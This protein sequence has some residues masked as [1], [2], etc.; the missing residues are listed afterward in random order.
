[1]GFSQ[2]CRE[3]ENSKFYNSTSW[4]GKGQRSQNCKVN[5]I[6]NC[7]KLSLF[8]CTKYLLIIKTSP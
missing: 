3:D 8:S 1:M 6:H 4:H 7:Q 2:C 5:N